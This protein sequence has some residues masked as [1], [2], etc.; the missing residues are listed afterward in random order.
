MLAFLF[1]FPHKHSFNSWLRPVLRMQQ[2]LGAWI[3]FSIESACQKYI[4]AKILQF[5][6]REL[7]LMDLLRVPFYCKSVTQAGR[8]VFLRRCRFADGGSGPEFLIGGRVSKLL[9][10]SFFSGQ[11]GGEG[12]AAQFLIESVCVWEITFAFSY[13]FLWHFK[14]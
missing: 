3:A 6:L 1:L 5:I 7:L 14:S 10:F 9:Q 8:M 12:E 11:G 4:W 13:N 2:K